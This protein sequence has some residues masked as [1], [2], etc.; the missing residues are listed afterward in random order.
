MNELYPTGN[1]EEAVQKESGGADRG[2]SDIT[3]HRTGLLEVACDDGGWEH[4][5]DVTVVLGPLA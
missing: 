4:L 5:A 2:T 1:S 3:V